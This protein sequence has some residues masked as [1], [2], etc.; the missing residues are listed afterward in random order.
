MKKRLFVFAMVLSMIFMAQAQ[1]VKGDLAPL[2]GQAKVNV[3]FIYD[4]VTYD[5]DSEAKFFKDNNDRDD[6]EQWKKDWTSTFRSDLWEPECLEDLNE[7]VKG[8]RMEFGNFKDATYTMVVKVTD[9]DPGSFA[10]PFSVP[11]RLTGEVSY[12]KTGSSDGFATIS[13]SKIYGNGY[14]M[15][16]VI[17][18]R[19]KFA[20]EE[21]GETIGEILNKKVK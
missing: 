8:L 17:E 2:K 19:V 13:F 5:G 7:E 20:F 6:F 3:E 1:K 14:A 21:L 11:S 16:P 10:G 15:T 4:G 12:V 9:I 18:H